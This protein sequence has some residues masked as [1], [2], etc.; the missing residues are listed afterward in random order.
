MNWFAI[1]AL[2]ALWEAVWWQKRIMDRN[3][4]YSKAFSHSRA[5]GLPLVVIGAADLGPTN[6]PWVGDINIDIEKSNTPN[7]IQCDITKRIPLPDNSCVVFVS[8]VLEYVDDLGSAMKELGRI[9]RD[10]VYIC[11]VQPWTF[12]GQLYPNCRRTLPES[13][14]KK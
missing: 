10:R 2:A 8:C 7:F 9:A 5:L 11:R 3:D 1:P 14:I 12:T 6:G 4:A 13:M